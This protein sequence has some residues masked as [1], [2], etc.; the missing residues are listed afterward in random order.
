MSEIA[1]LSALEILDSRGWPTI[2]TTCLLASGAQAVASVPSG[3][4]TGAAEAWELRDGEPQRYMG[5][6]CRQA[7]ANVNTVLRSVLSGRSFAG[8]QELDEALCALD[9]TANKQR[10]GANTLLS[11][12]IAFARAQAKE[13]GLPLFAHFSQLIGGKVNRFPRLTINLFSGGRHAGKQVAIQDV[14]IVPSAACSIDESL[15]MMNAIY[16]A[17]AEQ[18]YR[19]YGMRLLTADEGGLAPPF[20]SS[21]AMLQAAVSAI[22]GAGFKAGED[23][24]LALDIAASHFYHDGQ[25][26]L[27]NEPLSAERMIKALSDWCKRYPIVS[28]ED[29]LAED[30]WSH[31]SQLR[32]V[33]GEKVLILGDDLLCTN[34]DRIRRAVKCGACNGLLLKVNQIGTLSEAVVAYA[35]ARE[36]GWQV[37]IS[38]RSGETEDDW[39]A[40]LAVGWSADQ[41]KNGSITQSER[42]AKYN[43]LL[44][45]EADRK[46]PLNRWPTTS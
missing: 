29:G 19:R 8:Q 21:E 34:P 14:L 4:S 28:L 25:Y 27:D 17:A 43:R 42:L 11:V 6:G 12:S 5:R 9:G 36:A 31:W 39:A 32:L 37:T 18:T 22:T 16:H 23:V 2:K 10:L 3:R 46:L 30:D 38:V 1:T 7:A 13:A 40:D 44:E 41:F 35:L 33:L 26:R 24:H 15:V 20:E 45:I